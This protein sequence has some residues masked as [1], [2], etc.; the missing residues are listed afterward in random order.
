MET[1]AG[2]ER[3][4]FQKQERGWQTWVR[5]QHHTHHWTDACAQG[6]NLPDETTSTRSSESPTGKAL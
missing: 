5:A 2:Q 3:V 4:S 1:Q 6:L